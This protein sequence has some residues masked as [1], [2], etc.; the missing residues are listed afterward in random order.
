MLTT[1]WEEPVVNRILLSL[2][3]KG[4]LVAAAAMLGVSALTAG[5][6]TL[7]QPQVATAACTP[8][9]QYPLT[10]V[11]YCGLSG[12]TLS[13]IETSFHDYY[14]SGHDTNGNTDLQTAYNDV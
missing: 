9:D 3:K 1:Y 5:I 7:A 14:T 10:N 13:E 4:G 11:I 12:S 2:M 8:Q 6:M